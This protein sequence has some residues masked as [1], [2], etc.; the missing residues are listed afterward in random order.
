MRRRAGFVIFAAALLWCA[1]LPAQEQAGPE[2]EARLSA[3][4]AE[5]EAQIVRES[6][7]FTSE[8]LLSLQEIER[9]RAQRDGYVLSIRSL[10][11]DISELAGENSA[12]RE[13]VEEISARIEK[14]EAQLDEVRRFAG[15]AAPE[16]AELVAGSV[17]G[18][19][20]QAL[21]KDMS[22]LEKAIENSQEGA[23]ETARKVF[24]L[25]CRL[26]ARSRVVE[27]YRGKTLSVTG[28]YVDAAFV[29]AG[30]ITSFYLAAE[31]E[32]A[33]M[34]LRSPV[35]A[36][37]RR[38]ERSLPGGV[39]SDLR[40]TSTDIERI[41]AE[42]EA[43]EDL[44]RLPLDIS[45]D[46]AVG[47]SYGEGGLTAYLARGG[48]VMIPLLVVALLA[49]ILIVEKLI[50]LRREG[51]GATKFAG[52][53]VDTYR[54]KGLQSALA[55]AKGG[56]GA[57]ARVMRA[58][59]EKADTPADIFEESLHEAALAELPRLERS[60]SS[61][62][63]LATVSPLLGLLGTVTGMISTFDTIT[64]YGTSDPRLLSGGISEA[65]ITTMVGLVVAIPVL[66][67]HG[68]LSAKV[69]RIVADLEQASSRLIAA[70]NEGAAPLGTAGKDTDG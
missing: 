41:A 29:R 23:V 20:T 26:L 46:M 2:D 62:A 57:V 66:L 40:K 48:P 7:E 36:G 43:K 8:K 45:Q 68:F 39:V 30:E 19:D 15:Q 38:Y 44:V 42:P 5:L 59:L 22:A 47:V 56:R 33:G 65:L 61:I 67:I 54:T 49:A 9:L 69:D 28:I 32:E 53:T 3:A 18:S 60:L 21:L 10:R 55:L 63:V 14:D 1:G 50:S 4:I 16:L 17:D 35:D 12:G 64:A 11:D 13:E 58:G 34:L 24:D 27:H 25:A 70:V 52:E 31:G 6:E 51:R 37:G